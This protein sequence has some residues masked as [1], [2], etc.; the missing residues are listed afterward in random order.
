MPQKKIK[1]QQEI[2]EQEAERAA[3]REAQHKK[4]LASKMLMAYI[5]L[6]H[7]D[8]IDPDVLLNRVMKIQDLINVHHY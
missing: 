5:E 6:K 2:E 3:L 4:R 7:P 1:T 8:C